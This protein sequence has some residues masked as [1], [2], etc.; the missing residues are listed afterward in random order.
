MSATFPAMHDMRTRRAH[1]AAVARTLLDG[2]L[3]SAPEAVAVEWRQ[4]GE[5]PD[6]CLWPADARL[7]LVR[8]TGA[9]FA[10][11]GMR[12]WIDGR[13]IEIARTLIGTATL[14][15][16]MAC[17]ALPIQAPAVPPSGDL[18]RL[19]DG[20][21]RAVLLGSLGAA[22]MRGVAGPLLPAAEAR[23]TLCPLAIARPLV[24]QALAL[25]AEIPVEA[26]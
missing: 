21:G 8:V 15:R 20:S 16:V 17:P 13:R 14:A 12:L 18:Q 10:A 19:F 7:R 1:R 25:V 2:P 22:W 3:A 23:A 24:G 5:L 26:A 4:L 11:P 9:L 6:W